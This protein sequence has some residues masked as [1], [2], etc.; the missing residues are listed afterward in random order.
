MSVLWTNGNKKSDL[1]NIAHKLNDILDQKES[2]QSVIVDKVFCKSG[3][4]L[5]KYQLF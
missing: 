5:F 3:N 2:L 1:G 4:K